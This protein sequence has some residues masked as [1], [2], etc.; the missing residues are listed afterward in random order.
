MQKSAK[1][2]VGGFSSRRVWRKAQESL[3]ITRS[4]CAL[5]NIARVYSSPDNQVSSDNLVSRDP[6]LPNKSSSGVS[7]WADGIVFGQTTTSVAGRLTIYRVIGAV[8]K[9]P[10]RN[11]TDTQGL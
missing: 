4:H 7:F 3:A 10:G 5:N 2:L 11:L 8:L 6:A 1:R 9:K